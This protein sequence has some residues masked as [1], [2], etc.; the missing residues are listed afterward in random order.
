MTSVLK[1]LKGR[2][3]T[4]LLILLSAIDRKG[5]QSFNKTVNQQF[6]CKCR[7]KRELENQKNSDGEERSHVFR[8]LKKLSAIHPVQESRVPSNSG[9]VFNT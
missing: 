7:T 9:G 8:T 6:F 5:S 3:P 2:S 1:L 4:I